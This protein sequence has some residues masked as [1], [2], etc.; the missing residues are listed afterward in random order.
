MVVKTEWDLSPFFKS[1]DDSSIKKEREK[2]EKATKTFIAK[3]KPRDDY[4]RDPRIL[5]EALD[6]YEKLERAYSDGGKE[7]YYFWLRGQEND[8]DTDL[9]AKR[10]KVEEAYKKIFTEINFFTIN[11]SKIKENYQKIFLTDSQL[12]NYRHFLERVFIV[13][14]HTLSENEEKIMTMKSSTSYQNWTRMVSGFLSKEE[15]PVLDSDGTMKNKNF[16]EITTLLSDSNKKIRDS[17]VQAFNDILKKHVEVAEAE[18]NSVMENRKINDDLRNYPRPDTHR[19]IGDDM[20]TEVVDTLVKSVSD[21]FHVSK[22]YYAFKAKLLKLPRLAYHERNVQYG[23]INDSYTFEESVELVRNVFNKVDP[24]FS[25]VFDEF[26]KKGQVDAFP[27][28]GKRGGAFCVWWGPAF[29]TYVCLNYTNKLRDITT[30]AH[31]FGHAINSELS[32]K[33]NA[34]NFNTPVS[35]SEV[36]STFME[37]FVFDELLRKS[38]EDTRLALLVSSL[39]DDISTIFRQVACY[40]FEQEIHSTFKEKG[41]LSMKEIGEIFTKNMEAYMGNAVEQSPGSE[42]WWVYWSHIRNYFY[43]YSYASGLLIAKAL[44]KR[45]TENPAFISQVKDVFSSGCSDSPKNLFKRVGIDINEKKFWQEGLKEIEKRL[46][47]A[48]KLAKKLGKI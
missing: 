23:K 45:V 13:G 10:K 17:A 24:Y 44:Q 42:N 8:M 14:K 21:F 35:T 3:W 19:H 22:K 1:D 11:L 38:D 32:K 31:E 16:S 18:M 30:I 2:A 15:R 4:L 9:K 6:E 12:V 28:K 5:K 41:Y 27:R 25:N 36:A 47:D 43:V 39:G 46:D 7:G 26:L 48:E 37:D 34:L 33:Q 40:L 20:E 29:P